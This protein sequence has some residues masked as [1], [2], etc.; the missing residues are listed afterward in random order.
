LLIAA[1]GILVGAV[2]I[3]REGISA[4]GKYIDSIMAEE[5]L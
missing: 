1:A 5:Y 3:F 2:F 4:A